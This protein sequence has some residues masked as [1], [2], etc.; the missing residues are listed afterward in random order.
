MPAELI[1]PLSGLA[2]LVW[3]AVL[4]AVR[5]FDPRLARCVEPTTI[6]YRARLN[7]WDQSAYVL[8][9]GGAVF[10]LAGVL[11]LFGAVLHEPAWQVA[12]SL[13][14]LAVILWLTRAE[15]FT[16]FLT[17][18]VETGTLSWPGGSVQRDAVTGVEVTGNVVQ[19][20]GPEPATVF[21]YARSTDADA[22]A[23]WLRE[24][25]DVGTVVPSGGQ[26]NPPP[27]VS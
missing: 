5:R 2:C 21:R 16:Y 8:L 12:A 23:G 24:R 27:P 18:D 20:I 25:L 6:G 4:L 15:P 10:V 17:D 14:P 7:G 1:L 11:R 26:Q 3:L 22:L 9:V 19:L 13:I